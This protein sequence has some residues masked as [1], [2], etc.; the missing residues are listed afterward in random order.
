VKKLITHAEITFRW[1]FFV[2]V[3]LFLAAKIEFTAGSLSEKLFYHAKW[4]K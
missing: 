3:M 4:V 1:E 2:S